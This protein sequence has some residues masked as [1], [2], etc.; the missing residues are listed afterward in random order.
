MDIAIYPKEIQKCLFNLCSLLKYFQTIYIFSTRTSQISLKNYCFYLTA[1]SKN[2]RFQPFHRVVF[3]SSDIF[4]M[5]K[6]NKFEITSYI[7]ESFS[8]KWTCMLNK[9]NWKYVHHTPFIQVT[10][11]INISSEGCLWKSNLRQNTPLF[12]LWETRRNIHL[13]EVL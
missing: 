1:F 2:K 7:K 8:N 13:I 4:P 3:E 5:P 6:T 9:F 10:M 11:S 12:A